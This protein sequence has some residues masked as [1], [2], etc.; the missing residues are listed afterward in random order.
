MLHHEDI[1]VFFITETSC[2]IG[3][4][5]LDRLRAAAFTVID[6]PRAHDPNDAPSATSFALSIFT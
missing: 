2:G 5:A 3:S 4:F 6:C 1:D